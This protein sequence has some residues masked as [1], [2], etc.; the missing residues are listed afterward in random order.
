MLAVWYKK[1]NHISGGCKMKSSHGSS[2]T[3]PK[4]F[5]QFKRPSKI[6]KYQLP[7][8]SFLSLSPIV[9]LGICRRF[10][11]LIRISTSVKSTANGEWLQYTNLYHGS[12][13]DLTPLPNRKSSS[14]SYMLGIQMAVERLWGIKCLTQ[15]KRRKYGNES[16]YPVLEV[17]L[18]WKDLVVPDNNSDDP[19]KELLKVFQEVTPLDYLGEYRY[20]RT[21]SNTHPWPLTPRTNSENLIYRIGLVSYLWHLVNNSL[22]YSFGCVLWLLM[23]EIFLISNSVGKFLHKHEFWFWLNYCLCIKIYFTIEGLRLFVWVPLPIFLWL[24]KNGS[25]LVEWASF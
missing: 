23:C 5:R 13:G 19:M 12:Q 10:L 11:W 7:I 2:W 15:I 20:V 3:S 1:S 6:I 8:I 21:T 25:E 16:S 9:I 17:T 14:P 18:F 24:A 4:F 22:L